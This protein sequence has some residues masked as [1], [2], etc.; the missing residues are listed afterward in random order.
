ML[1]VSY[2]KWHILEPFENVISYAGV[3]GSVVPND[4]YS[5]LVFSSE[6]I[7]FVDIPITNG[8]KLNSNRYEKS[9]LS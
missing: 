6:N 2:S 1:C 4:G 8:L 9:S 3:L 7:S 5:C